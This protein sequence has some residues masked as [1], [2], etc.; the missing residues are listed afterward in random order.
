MLQKELAKR[1]RVRYDTKMDGNGWLEVSS[2]GYPPPSKLNRPP[3]SRQQ[4]H[5]RI[6]NAIDRPSVTQKPE[7]FFYFTARR[8]EPMTIFSERPYNRRIE[9]LMTAIPNFKPRGVGFRFTET[10]TVIAVTAAT[11]TE[12][13]T[14]TMQQI[15]CPPFQKRFAEYIESKETPMTY[16]RP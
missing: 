7:G 9:R 16:A 5:N 3:L 2:D 1:L 13:L 15:R 11:P 10:Q 8:K 12:T 4:L 14:A 6:C